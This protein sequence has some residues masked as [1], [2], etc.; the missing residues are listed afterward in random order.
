MAWP[1]TRALL[2][3]RLFTLI[4]PPSDHRHPVLA[5]AALVVGGAPACEFQGPF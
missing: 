2:L 5:P 1:S 3:L 4:F